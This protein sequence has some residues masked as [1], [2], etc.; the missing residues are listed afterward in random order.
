MLEESPWTYENRLQRYYDKAHIED[1]K[2]FVDTFIQGVYNK[3][4]R[5]LLLLHAPPLN[6]REPL[7]KAVQYYI[8]QLLIY[9]ETTLDAEPATIA[10][11]GGMQY[12]LTGMRQETMRQIRALHQPLVPAEEKEMNNPEAMEIGALMIGDRKEDD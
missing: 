12:G 11:L 2:Q 4:L 7:K 3:E 9:A 5:K 6:T 10:G 8:T 1:E